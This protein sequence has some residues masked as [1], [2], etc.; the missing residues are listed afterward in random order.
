MPHNGLV[1]LQS[2]HNFVNTLERLLTVLA[3]KHVTVFAQIDHAAGA[4]AAGLILRP[5]TLVV[6]GN[7]ATGTPLMQAD[8]V[9]GIDL[10]LKALVWQHADGSVKLSYDA[11]YG[12]RPG[13]GLEARPID[14]SK[15]W[16]LPSTPL[17]DTQ[18][19]NKDGFPPV[20]A[21]YDR[22]DHSGARRWTE[23][24]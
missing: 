7:P 16:R 13:T 15:V 10:P 19:A 22:R 21:R 23:V 17:H 8:Q 6:F 2:A 14:W 18:Q 11:P 1:T 5:T 24:A 4:V 20:A 3:E 12:S 9:A